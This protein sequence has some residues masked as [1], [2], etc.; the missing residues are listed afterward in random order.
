MAIIECVELHLVHSRGKLGPGSS[1]VLH[2]CTLHT[3]LLCTLH[4]CTGLHFPLVY[5]APLHTPKLCTGL[6]CTVYHCTDLYFLWYSLHIIPL[7]RSTLCTL[8]KPTRSTAQCFPFHKT[9]HFSIVVQWK[10]E[11]GGFVQFGAATQ[12][13]SV[14]CI[15]VHFKSRHC[16]ASACLAL[17]ISPL[18]FLLKFNT[19]QLSEMHFTALQFRALHCIT[20]QSNSIE[21]IALDL[22]YSEGRCSGVYW[23]AAQLR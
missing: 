2:H 4:Y 9:Q 3:P 12:W 13:D 11:R 10:C 20:F 15:P 22:Q 19:I 16:I 23:G 8:H 17:I 18:Q 7:Q 21:C 14:Q 1:I 6:L 5:F